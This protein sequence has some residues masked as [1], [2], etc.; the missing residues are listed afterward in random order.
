LIYQKN[1]GELQKMI[2]SIFFGD[3]DYVPQFIFEND[4]EL[5]QSLA[6][7]MYIM[8]KMVPVN[9][10]WIDEITNKCQ[11]KFSYYG[12]TS[13]LTLWRN[14]KTGEALISVL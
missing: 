1:K 3:D 4:E 6:D 10:N 9:D 14:P 2:G 12:L 8:Y 7:T 5:F 11:T 13:T